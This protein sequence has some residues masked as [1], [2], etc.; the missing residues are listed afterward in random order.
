[1]VDGNYFFSVARLNLNGALATSFG[2]NGY[3]YAS[4]APP[5]ASTVS[6]YP[7]SA[8]LTTRGIVVA[9][10]VQTSGLDQF[11]VA[12]LQYEHIFASSFE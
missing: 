5:D 2:N 1:M 11:G 10:Q 4:F 7:T 12:R 3:S 8:I 6:D 9:G